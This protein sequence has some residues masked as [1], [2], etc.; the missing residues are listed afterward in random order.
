MHPISSSDTSS[1]PIYIDSTMMSA[2]RSCPQRFY[3]EFVLNIAEHTTSPHLHA[4]AAFARGLDVARRAYWRD[5]CSDNAAIARGLC[6]LWDYFGDYTPNDP[7]I[8]KTWDR[9]SSAFV[10]Y[11]DEYPFEDDHAKPLLLK[12]GSPCVEFSFSIP[13]GVRHPS[14]EEFIFTGRMDMLA[15]Y[16]NSLAIVDEKTTTSLGASWSGK[17]DLRSQF[18]GYIYAARYYGYEVKYTLVRGIGLLK[19]EINYLE[20]IIPTRDHLVERW[21]QQFMRDLHRMRECY[22]EGVWD[23]DLGDSC[24]DFGGCPYKTLCL[25]ANPEQWIPSYSTRS[26]NPLALDPTETRKQLHP[27]FEETV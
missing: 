24:N 5:G 2:F 17:W 27:M 9:L 16:L 15:T 14:G 21:H 6:A 26:W 23:Y 11:F 10:C 18:L 1:L 8:T 12:D 13:M 7:R 25:S 3:N 22:T 4:G 19:N 20:T